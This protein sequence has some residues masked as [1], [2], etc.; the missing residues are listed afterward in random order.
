MKTFKEFLTEIESAEIDGYVLNVVEFGEN[1]VL[2]IKIYLGTGK[3]QSGRT[4]HRL[5]MK[6]PKGNYFGTSVDNPDVPPN[7]KTKYMKVRREKNV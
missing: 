7:V 2:G 5:L 4:F 3:T 6:T 1:A